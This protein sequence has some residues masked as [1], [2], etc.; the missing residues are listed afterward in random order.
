MLI[1]KCNFC[2]IRN[3]L[4]NI[5]FMMILCLFLISY[6]YSLFFSFLTIYFCFLNIYH[7]IHSLLFSLLP[8][9]RS[10]PPSLL[11]RNRIRLYS[12]IS[13]SPNLSQLV[14]NQHIPLFFT[15][16]PLAIHLSFIYTRLLWLSIY[17]CPLQGSLFSSNYLSFQRQESLSLSVN[18]SFL[19]RIYF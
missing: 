11:T 14:S 19:Y 4:F 9:S 2:N 13:F 10:Y 3:L 1:D 7:F 5:C 16:L 18:I 15:R 17:L 12:C 6:L 8:I